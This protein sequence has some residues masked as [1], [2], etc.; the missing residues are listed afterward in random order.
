MGDRTM[1][2]DGMIAAMLANTKTIA[3]VGA[4]T[5]EAR[6]SYAV[7]AYLL[8][9]GYEVIPVNPGAA[10]QDILGQMCYASLS[11]IPKK[12]DMVDIFR[13][14]QYCLPIVEEAIAIGA[15][16]IWMQIG[17]QNGEARRLATNAGLSVIEDRCTK[18]E[19][20]RLILGSES[21]DDTGNDLSAAAGA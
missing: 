2:A 19:H 10:G 4:S 21:L 16:Y 18:I 12:I 7:M 9:H 1:K 8:R 15:Q 11:E 3:L 13:Q 6:P 17:V 20:T 5:N 14:S